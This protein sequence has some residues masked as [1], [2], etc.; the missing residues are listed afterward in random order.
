MTLA[1]T[2]HRDFRGRERG[3][4]N[5]HW[6]DRSGNKKRRLSNQLETSRVL[7]EDRRV[8]RKDLEARCK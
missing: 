3:F 6:N 5:L 7:E 2:H 1:L 8:L 4:A